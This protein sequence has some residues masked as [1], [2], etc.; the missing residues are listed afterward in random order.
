MLTLED[1]VGRRRKVY[2]NPETTEIMLRKQVVQDGSA[3]EAD[4][5]K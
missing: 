4:G 3:T 5:R 1:K 2:K